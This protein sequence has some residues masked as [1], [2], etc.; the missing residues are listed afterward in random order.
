MAAV[1]ILAKVLG[2]NWQLWS[3]LVAEHPGESKVKISVGHCHVHQGNKGKEGKVYE[4]YISG[5]TCV[6]G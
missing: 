1:L 4:R 2:W 5:Y 6:I 3:E